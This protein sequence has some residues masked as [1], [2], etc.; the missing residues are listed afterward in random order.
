[1]LL[2]THD[3][4]VL[5]R[6]VQRT[7]E[8][9]KG[10]IFSYDGGYE[11]FLAAKANRKALAERVESNRQNFL[12]RELEWLRR[13][14]KARTTKSKARVDRAEEQLYKER[15]EQEREAN[16]SAES[17]RS[18]KTILELRKACFEIGGKKLFRDLHLA[19]VKGERIG[20]VGPNGTGKTSFL[21]CVLEEQSLTSGELVL[22]KNTQVGYLDQ[23][24]GGLR[25]DE[26]IL[27]NVAGENA[28][29]KVDGNPLRAGSYL[30][31]FLFDGRA[32]RQKVGILSGGERARVCLA[33]LLC[34]PSNL[35]VLDEPT[36]DLDVATLG[37]LEEMLMAYEGCALIVSHDR[38][39][40]DRV[41]TSILA[42]EGDER[43]DLHRG[44]YTAYKEKV[45][46]EQA[47]KERQ[48]N[49]PPKQDLTQ[50]TSKDLGSKKVA[51]RK[52]SFKEKRELEGLMDKI[53]AEELRFAE[54]EKKVADPEVYS[55]GGEALAALASELEEVRQQ[56]EEM[57]LRWEELES[58]RLD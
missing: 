3:R 4:Y 25:D 9:E 8:L 43:V 14:P 40:L 29:L 48:K 45:E 36:N 15:P 37:A 49:S 38:W 32:Q 5:N 18:G 1:L 57:T 24:R 54:L 6:V 42:F 31:R 34:R 56:I 13:Q 35:L 33:K 52:L 58:L 17:M 46:K 21:K 7:L 10:E 27:E 23:L 22:G 30:E 19:L 26:T 12:R 53:E 51:S 50:K 47:R 2:I 20:I 44:G 16:L 55:Q 41:A 39:F 28:Y 11:S